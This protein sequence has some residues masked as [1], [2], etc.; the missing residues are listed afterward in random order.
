MYRSNLVDAIFTKYL[1]RRGDPGVLVTRPGVSL[2]VAGVLSVALLCGGMA[3]SSVSAAGGSSCDGDKLCLTVNATGTYVD[4]IV[5]SVSVPG[6]TV[7]GV[8]R[9]WC[10]GVETTTTDGRRFG[11]H[12]CAGSD[13]PSFAPVDVKASVAAG[14]IFCMRVSATDPESTYT[15][16]G[17]PC[18]TVR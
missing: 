16:S 2:V 15:P 17:N 11:R 6:G 1:G 18:V 14:T 13:T 7:A 5:M 9:R 8:P 4:S 12:L 10:G 3:S